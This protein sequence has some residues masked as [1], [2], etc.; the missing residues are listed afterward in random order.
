MALINASLSGILANCRIFVEIL[1]IFKTLTSNGNFMAK[2]FGTNGIRG[3]FHELTP[4]L[5][6]KAAR[7]FGTYCRKG[8]ILVARDMRLTSECLS[9]AVKSG[10]AS[11]GCEAVDLGLCSAPAAEFMI[12]KEN[13]NGLMIITASHNPKEWNALKFVD[14]NGITV[15]KERGEEIEKLMEKIEL[16]KWNEVKPMRK[17]EHATEQHIKAI[18]N[19]S[20]LEK[21]KKADLKIALDFGNGTSALYAEMFGKI[22][23]TVAINSKIDGTFPGRASEPSEA[24]ISE[25]IELVKKEKCDAGF[26]WDGDADRFVMVDGEGNFIVGDRVFALSVLHRAKQGGMKKIITTVATSRA[27]GDVAEKFRAKTIYTMVGAPYLSEAMLSENAEIA[28]EEVGGVIWRE[29]SLAKDGIMTAMKMLGMIAEK[30]LSE[31]VAEL[32]Q[33]HNAKTKIPVSRERKKEIIEKFAKTQKGKNI[34]TLDG[35][36]VNFPDSW[37]I[38]R[39]SGTEDYIRIFAEA[40]TKK[41]AEKL[42]KEYEEIIKKL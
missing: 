10:L 35:A 18:E 39:A 30:P 5:A 41:K 16:A 40:K 4:E 15:S 9:R 2:Y 1:H 31:L 7:A 36:R 20:D 37:V 33:Y 13:A 3:L 42:V 34:I 27:A 12:K 32:P 17:T 21:I 29:I 25:L 19:F 28:G 6:M 11:A 23:K 38:V 22:V 14:G 8:K 26:A 24:N